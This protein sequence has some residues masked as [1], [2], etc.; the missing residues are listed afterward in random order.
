MISSAVIHGIGDIRF[1]CSSAGGV[2]E[3]M[4]TSLTIPKRAEE[5]IFASLGKLVKK[6]SVRSICFDY[7]F[8]MLCLTLRTSICRFDLGYPLF[9]ALSVP[10]SPL[11]TP[12]TSFHV[13]RWAEIACFLDGIEVPSDIGVSSVMFERA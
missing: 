6:G 7:V 2:R 3:Q 13:G 10:E 5:C 9:N 4:Q 1:T 11:P 8:Q 12:T